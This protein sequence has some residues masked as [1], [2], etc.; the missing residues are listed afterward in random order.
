M[1]D[2]IVLCLGVDFCAVSTACT[3]RHI[4]FI[5]SG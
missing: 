3:F 1:V 4:F 2:L 5:K